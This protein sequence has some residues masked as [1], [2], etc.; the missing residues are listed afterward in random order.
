MSQKPKIIFLCNFLFRYKCIFNYC[1]NLLLGI[2]F[3]SNLVLSIKYNVIFLN[4]YLLSYF[5]SKTFSMSVVPFLYHYEDFQGH[6][7]WFLLHLIKYRNITWKPKLNNNDILDIYCFNNNFF[8][9]K[10]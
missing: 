9:S 3:L 1:N 7:G 5:T 4:K 10:R 8:G 6:N 2:D